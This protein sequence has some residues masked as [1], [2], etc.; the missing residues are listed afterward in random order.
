LQKSRESLVSRAGHD[1]ITNA[2]GFRR[3]LSTLFHCISCDRPVHLDRYGGITS[4]PCVKK[5][6]GNKDLAKTDSGTRLPLH[7]LQSDRKLRRDMWRDPL[8]V[9]RYCGGN[10]TAFVNNPRKAQLRT[11]AAH[12][13]FETPPNA[14][15]L[16]EQ[17]K[18][19]R[20]IV[21]YLLGTDGQIY[22]GRYKMTDLRASQFHPENDGRF[23]SRSAESGPRMLSEQRH[24]TGTMSNPASVATSPRNLPPIGQDVLGV[25]TTQIT[26]RYDITQE[27]PSNGS[28]GSKS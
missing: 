3:P 12:K 16:L 17:R 6:N 14:K 10:Y 20:T 27:K 22:R 15:E 23:R 8:A 11:N 1:I 19:E 5:E 25:R 21:N 2:A 7:A 4:K 26:D 18:R 28:F 24:V 13:E 9:D